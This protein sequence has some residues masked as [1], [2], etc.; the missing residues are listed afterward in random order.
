MEVSREFIFVDVLYRRRICEAE[1]RVGKLPLNVALG[2]FLGMFERMF[3]GVSVGA[4]EFG[5]LVAH[6]PTAKHLTMDATNA[7]AM[8]VANVPAAE[9]SANGTHEA[10]RERIEALSALPD[11]LPVPVAPVVPGLEDAP[12]EPDTDTE[13]EEQSRKRTRDE[14]DEQASLLEALVRQEQEEQERASAPASAP[15]LHP[16]GHGV[17]GI[18]GGKAQAMAARQASAQRVKRVKRVARKAGG[19]HR[20]RHIGLATKAARRK[21]TGREGVVKRP[22]RYRSGTVAIREIRRYQKS[23]EL[24]IRKQPFQRLVREV[25]SDFKTDIRFQGSA[26]LA[27]QEASEAHLV[28]LFEDT[29]L[30]AIHAKR[31]TIMPKDMQLARRLRRDDTKDGK[32]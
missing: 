25:A 1:T 29:N 2:I 11:V 17:Y 8:A 10:A 4:S 13:T 31:V 6:F 27:L 22:H 20:G 24:L 12:T 28:G 19:G 3:L 14:T 15:A 26:V 5:W 23:T 7:P 21:R 16:H 30:C 18:G 9:L 32:Q